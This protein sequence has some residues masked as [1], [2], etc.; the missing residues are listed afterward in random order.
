M[1]RP[2]TDTLEA[3]ATDAFS[4]ID[5][6]RSGQISLR[7]FSEWVLHE[8]SAMAYLA[9]FANTRVIYENQV[10]YDLMLK[11]ICTAF[12]NFSEVNDKEDQHIVL[13]S[14][15]FCEEMIQRYCPA[16]EKHEI[17]FFLRTMKSIMGKTDDSEN[18]TSNRNTN[19]REDCATAQADKTHFMI[20]LD[21]F[22]L[23]ISPY[24]A[25]IAAD[26]DGEHLIN[27]HELR[28]L[29]WLLRG[30]EPSQAVVDSFMKSLDDN[31]DGFLSAIEWVSYAL[32]VNK[33]TGSQSFANQIHLLFATSD[34]N[35]DAVLSLPELEAGLSHVFAEHL[36]RVKPL[37]KTT[38]SP[39]SAWEE[40]TA[41]ERVE[42]R[43][44]SQYSSITS[45]VA[46]LAKE[47][48]QNWM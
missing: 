45:L 6:D 32:E 41:T 31:R 36:H 9:K 8:R 35:G 4:H 38:A 3:L 1:P 11:E 2:A 10:Q 39:K 5:A 42:R 24:V 40:L 7:E 13:C 48:M 19:Q 16:T 18:T 46:D 15:T 12:M 44:K 27:I 33:E 43:R 26:D 14:E 17:A 34:L 21:A 47:I 22:F 23:V 20:S 29:V 25:F 30:S 28:I 37:P